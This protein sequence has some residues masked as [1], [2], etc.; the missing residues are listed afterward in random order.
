[1]CPVNCRGF[2]ESAWAGGARTAVLPAGSA[3]CSAVQLILLFVNLAGHF[4]A[5]KPRFVL[6]PASSS[7]PLLLLACVRAQHFQQRLVCCVS[8]DVTASMHDRPQP[9]SIAPP[10]THNDIA[11]S[12][13]VGTLQGIGEYVSCAWHKSI[14]CSSQ[15]KLASS[16]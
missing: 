13:A 5:R 2:A 11:G 7:L 1:M 16:I 8:P 4:R 14:S 9:V 12:S 15:S 6:L 10:L 3:S